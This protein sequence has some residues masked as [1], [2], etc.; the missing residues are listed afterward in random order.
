MKL[1]IAGPRPDFACEDFVEAAAIWNA[2]GWTI[3]EAEA[4]PAG[5][6]Y[7]AYLRRDLNALLNVDALAVLPGWEESSGACVEALVAAS[8]GI[9]LMDAKTGRAITTDLI[10]NREVARK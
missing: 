8:L 5:A 3:I 4:L 2:C 6:T 1:Y 9:P 10:C 7:D